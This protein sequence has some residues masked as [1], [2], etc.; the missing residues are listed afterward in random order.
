MTGSNHERFIWFVLKARQRNSHTNHEPCPT[1]QQPGAQELFA[2][3][4]GNGSR[5]SVEVPRP[6]A[7]LHASL[8]PCPPARGPAA[9]VRV[10]TCRVLADA[11]AA[12]RHRACRCAGPVQEHGRA[13]RARAEAGAYPAAVDRQV[14][15]SALKR[16][17]RRLASCSARADCADHIPTARWTQST[18]C[19]MLVRAVTSTRCAA[20]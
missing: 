1:M 14:G 20:S 18:R 17:H 15:A 13:R 3:S 7:R 5:I 8:P 11:T 4:A 9:R 10:F 6:P 2:Q 12:P 19:T 16:V